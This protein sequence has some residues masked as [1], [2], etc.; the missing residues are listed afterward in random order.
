VLKR[1]WLAIW[2]GLITFCVLHF[3]KPIVVDRI[4]KLREAAHHERISA[5]N[6]A[7]MR[8]TGADAVSL[9]HAEKEFARRRQYREAVEAECRSF[10]Y[11]RPVHWFWPYQ[12][13]QAT[14]IQAWK[15][16]NALR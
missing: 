10:V 11:W 2:G 12:E 15:L 13:F 6:L 1:L 9:R 16:L 4:R 7:R 14:G 8:E 3:D 5:G